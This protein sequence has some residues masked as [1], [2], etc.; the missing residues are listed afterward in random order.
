MSE[1]QTTTK[2]SDADLMKGG[3]GGENSKMPEH[4]STH[5]DLKGSA[6]KEEPKQTVKYELNGKTFASASEMSQYVADLEKKVVTTQTTTTYQPATVFTEKKELIDG[7]PI[8]D[9]LFENPTKVL[10]HFRSQVQQEV[11]LKLTQAE[12]N[13][14]FWSDFYKTNPDLDG[15]QDL[16]DALASKNWGTWKDLK[17]DDFAK[18]VST[19]S[20]AVLKKMGLDR[21]VEIPNN[22]TAALSSGNS[23]ATTQT[24]TEKRETTFIDEM[25]A[26]RAKR[27]KV[28]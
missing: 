4:G 5:P 20:R 21:A 28:K 1:T 25:K 6:Q 23:G 14:R 3:P 16:V 13:K 26:A 8:D 22:N 12:N 17:I 24:S 18:A 7:R 11:D 2:L 19:E 9:V 15:K 10:N 27:T